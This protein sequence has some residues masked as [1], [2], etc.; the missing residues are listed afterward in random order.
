MKPGIRIGQTVAFEIDVR[1]D[2][3]AHFEDITVHSLYSTAA[4]LTHMEWAARQHILPVLA[5]GEEGVGYH[6]EIDHMAPV[7]LDQTVR[8]VATVTGLLP[9]KVICQCEVFH[10]GRRVG[11]AKVVQA[12]LPLAKLHDKIA[13]DSAKHQL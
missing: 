8:I 5:G 11:Q 10:Q 1:E 7:S 3:R 12:L 4:M 13:Q 6:M 9:D 2:M